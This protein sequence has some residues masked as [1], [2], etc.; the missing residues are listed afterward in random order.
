MDHNVQISGLNAAACT[1]ATP[2]SIHPVTG[3][4]AGSL[5]TC[6]LGF[7]P[8]GLALLLAAHRLGNISEFQYLLSS[9]PRFGFILARIHRCSG[10]SKKVAIFRS[11][12]W[13]LE[14]ALVSSKGGN[15]DPF[16]LE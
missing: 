12:G 3:M 5:R 7:D 2:G 14:P 15:G 11:P 8:V 9:S 1:L 10:V 13:R 4:H 6:W 16:C